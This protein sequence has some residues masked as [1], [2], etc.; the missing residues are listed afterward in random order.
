MP[1]PKLSA[2]LVALALTVAAAGTAGAAPLQPEI[3]S[4]AGGTVVQD[5]YWGRG[6]VTYDGTKGV[7]YAGYAN[8]DVIGPVEDF[9]IRGLTWAMS[10]SVLT[11]RIDTNYSPA[12]TPAPASTFPGDLFLAT[13]GWNPCGTAATHYA[14]DDLAST[15]TLWD[16]AI[17]TSDG[18][19][20]AVGSAGGIATS[21]ATFGATHA[22]NAW[23][24]RGNQP[25]AI[26]P[27]AIDLGTAWSNADAS[28]F[29]YAID[30]AGI[31]DPASLAMSWAMSCGNDVIQAS[32]PVPEPG[33]LALL[34]LG[35]AGTTLA[36]RRKR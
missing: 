22:A 35:L 8:R 21:D 32:I 24:Y 6:P 19:L 17:R 12:G 20:F 28:T 14:C 25:I 5:D 30:L 29:T 11:I 1:L 36:R 31:G 23:I 18:H 16:Y 2:P 27:G 4:L 13:G 15:G 33:S 10:G 34:A 26:G 3:G 9:D 7:P